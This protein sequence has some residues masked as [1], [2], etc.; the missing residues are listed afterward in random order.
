MTRVGSGRA[1]STCGATT[2][3]SPGLHSLGDLS[4]DRR[5]ILHFPEEK[6]IWSVGSG[7]GGNAL[8]GKKCH[9]LRHRLLA[10]APGGLARRAHADHR[11]RGSRGSDHV[12]GRGD[13]ERVGQDEPRDGRSRS[14]PAGARGRSAT[15][16]RGCGS[17]R[18][19]SS[20]RSTPSAASSASRPTRAPRPTRTRT[21]MVRSNTIFTN[22]ALTPSQRAVVGRAH[23][24]GAGRAH[25][26]GRDGRGSR[27]A[28][29]PLIRTRASP[30]SPSSV[31]RSRRTGKIRRACRSP[32]SSSARAAP[33]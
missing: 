18:T 11:R 9:A 30:C 26:T 8:L 5:L 12:P 6:L 13:A 31:R 1:S 3:S 17:T 29:R 28:G 7:Y 27:R 25:W 22:V 2:T 21:A 14:C 24:D 10:G 4:P 32:A 19:A 16:S 33:A 23:A 20:A 15:T